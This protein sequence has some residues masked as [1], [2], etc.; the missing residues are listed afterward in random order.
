MDQF[1]A[2]R[3]FQVKQDRPKNDFLNKNGFSSETFVSFLLKKITLGKKFKNIYSLHN[4]ITSRK[5]HP[6]QKIVS[7]PQKGITKIEEPEPE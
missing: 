2:L 4:S 3:D 5:E 7:R 1:W 6:K